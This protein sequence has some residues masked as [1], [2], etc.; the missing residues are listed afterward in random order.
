MVLASVQAA[1]LGAFGLDSLTP[2]PAIVLASIPGVST[3]VY[4]VG[5]K[6]EVYADS[7]NVTFKWFYGDLSANA[8]ATTYNFVYALIEQPFSF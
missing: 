6:I 2:L 4:L 5:A 7:T 3:S 1:S 8:F